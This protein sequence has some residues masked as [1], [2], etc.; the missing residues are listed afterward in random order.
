VSKRQPLQQIAGL[1]AL[2][3]GISQTKLGDAIGAGLSKSGDAG[4]AALSKLFNI[5][6]TGALPSTNETN[7]P[8][9]RTPDGRAATPNGDGT[10][11]TADGQ[12]V[13]VDG[14]PLPSPNSPPDDNF[15]FDENA[16]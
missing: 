9:I 1:G 13:G 14:T 10:Y 16:I 4:M 5:S 6:G 3:A 12:I 15:I 7:L 2:G 8:P 11:T